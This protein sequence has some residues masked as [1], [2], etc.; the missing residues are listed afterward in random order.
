[1][2]AKLAELIAF[3]GKTTPLAKSP[4][5]GGGPGGSKPSRPSSTCSI[6]TCDDFAVPVALRLWDKP[7]AS[8]ICPEFAAVGEELQAFAGPDPTAVLPPAS[9]RP[10]FGG[11]RARSPGPHLPCAAAAVRWV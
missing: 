1:M 10:W 7:G 8:R 9:A 6:S 4:S 2:E 11:T 3:G 5:S